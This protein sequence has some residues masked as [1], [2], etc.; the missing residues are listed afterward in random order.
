MSFYFPVLIYSVFVNLDL[1]ANMVGGFMRT[2]ASSPHKSGTLLTAKWLFETHPLFPLFLKPISRKPWKVSRKGCILILGDFI[3]GKS[4][5]RAM[6]SLCISCHLWALCP[7][8][9]V[10][11]EP[12]T[13][14]VDIEMIVL[15]ENRYNSLGEIISKAAK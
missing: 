5:F 13:L 11:M 15:Q 3:R 1:I 9:V 4:D 8:W 10:M 7:V 14:A 12:S 6:P 2:T